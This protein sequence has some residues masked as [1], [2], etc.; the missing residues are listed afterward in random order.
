MTFYERAGYKT[1][2]VH[3]RH[4]SGNVVVDLTSYYDVLCDTDTTFCSMYLLQL[5]GI[6]FL[7]GVLDVIVVICENV[8]TVDFLGLW[9]D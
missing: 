9:V 8:E 3:V 6:S 1:A 7:F 5:I 4:R 2:L